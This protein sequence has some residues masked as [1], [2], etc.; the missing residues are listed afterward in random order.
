MLWISSENYYLYDI[1]I[2]KVWKKIECHETGASRCGFYN[3]R[4]K[5]NKGKSWASY[6]DTCGDTI[7]NEDD[8]RVIRFKWEFQTCGVSEK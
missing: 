8:T 1:I 3:G 5:L 7:S 6:R 4:V 2:V